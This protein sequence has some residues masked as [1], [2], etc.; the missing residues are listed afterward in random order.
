MDIYIIMYPKIPPI[1][2]TEATAVIAQV[3]LKIIIN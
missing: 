1:K 2:Y 3:I